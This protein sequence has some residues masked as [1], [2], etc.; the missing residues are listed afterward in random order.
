MKKLILSILLITSNFAI[1]HAGESDSSSETLPRMSL[2]EALW[3]SKNYDNNDEGKRNLDLQLKQLTQDQ[4][5]LREADRA[6]KQQYDSFIAH[7]QSV[8]SDP[9]RTQREVDSVNS[10]AAQYRQSEANYNQRVRDFKAQVQKWNQFKFTVNQSIL[11]FD[12]K[13][14]SKLLTRKILNTICTD[15]NKSSAWCIELNK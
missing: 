9:Y 5:D 13:C 1:T 8:A 4:Q 12:E 3:C 7:K 10:E 15:E 2:E 11:S 14:N 6:L